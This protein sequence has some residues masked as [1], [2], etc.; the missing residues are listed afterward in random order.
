[1]K[2]HS[3]FIMFAP[4]DD[5][6]IALA[7]QCENAGF[8]GSCAAPIASLMAELYLKGELPDSPEV[9]FR[10]NRALTVSSQ[11]LPKPKPKTPEGENLPQPRNAGG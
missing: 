7:V 11:P 2:D 4:W 5:P 9:R 6:E 8:G 3:V 1:M 10:M